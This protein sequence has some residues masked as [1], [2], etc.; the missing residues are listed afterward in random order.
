MSWFRTVLGGPYAHECFANLFWIG[1]GMFA[2][3]C[4]WRLAGL[5]AKGVFGRK[6]RRRR[7]R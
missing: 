2:I 5:E 1:L 4:M 3:W 7:L 6:G